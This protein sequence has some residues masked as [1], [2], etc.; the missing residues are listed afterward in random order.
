MNDSD[1]KNADQ[2]KSVHTGILHGG[3]TKPSHWSKILK[4][5]TS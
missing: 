3:T 2:K 5:D 1:P 4:C